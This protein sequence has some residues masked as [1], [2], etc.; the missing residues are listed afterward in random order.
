MHEA[1]G[2]ILSVYGKTSPRSELPPE[3]V[4][5][6]QLGPA[7]KCKAEIARLEGEKF[8]IQGEIDSKCSHDLGPR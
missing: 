4:E 5:Q 7:E 1:I 3:W 8:K 6:V 2:K